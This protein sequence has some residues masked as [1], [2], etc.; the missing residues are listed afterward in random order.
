MLHFFPFYDILYFRFNSNLS[1]FLDSKVVKVDYRIKLCCTLYSK[2]LFLLKIKYTASSMME[3]LQEKLMLAHSVS[4]L[5][6]PLPSHHQNDE[7]DA[8]I[9]FSKF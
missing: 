3:P 1:R 5:L 4:F 2:L 9:D 7:H 6:S 8:S